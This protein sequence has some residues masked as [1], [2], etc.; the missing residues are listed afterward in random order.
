MYRIF[1]PLLAVFLFSANSYAQTAPKLVNFDTGLLTWN[2]TQGSG[3]PATEFRTKCSTTS[4]GPHTIVKS[5]PKTLSGPNFGAAYPTFLPGPGRYFCIL[6]AANV[7]AN[8][9]LES[10][11]TVEAAGDVQSGPAPGT[12]L[13]FQ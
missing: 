10:P 9:T 3:G 4:G 5:I 11:P 8:G 13:S 1:L 6:T 12:V 2:W 7:T